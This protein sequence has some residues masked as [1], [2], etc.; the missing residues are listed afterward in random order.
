MFWLQ[1]DL[2]LVPDVNKCEKYNFNPSKTKHEVH[3]V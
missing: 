1:L 3:R 2:Q